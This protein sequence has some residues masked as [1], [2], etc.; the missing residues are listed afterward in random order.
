[1]SE[2][3]AKRYFMRSLSYWSHKTLESNMSLANYRSINTAQTL[4]F[5]AEKAP[6]H[7]DN[8]IP[9][10][11]FKLLKAVALFGANASGKSN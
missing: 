8:L 7:S 5:V 3:G 11:G 6:R 9:C 2:N 1:M 10:R 4:S